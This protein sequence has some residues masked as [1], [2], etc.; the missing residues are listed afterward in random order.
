MY[1]GKALKRLTLL[2]NVSRFVGFEPGPVNEAEHASWHD[3]A[4]CADKTVEIA[5][6]FAVPMRTAVL[7]RGRILN[8]Y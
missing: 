3:S 1:N 4:T 2:A 6:W 5:D 7:D 8:T